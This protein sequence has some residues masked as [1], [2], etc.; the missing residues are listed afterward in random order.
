MSKRQTP[1]TRPF[2]IRLTDAERDAL[3]ARAGRTPLGTFIKAAVLS[4][5]LT[6]PRRRPVRP[7]TDHVAIARVLAALGDSR[8]SSN[9]NQLAK[10]VHLGTLPV[11]E[12]TEAELIA[13]CADI[14]AIRRDLLEALGLARSEPE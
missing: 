11:T 14:A 13:A 5:N 3:S 2:S 12:E 8:L 1:E 9:L 6:P 4:G 10:A 7:I